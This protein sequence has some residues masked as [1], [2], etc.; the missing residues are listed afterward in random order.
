MSYYTAV[1]EWLELRMNEGPATGDRRRGRVTRD[2]LR[3]TLNKIRRTD[4]ERPTWQPPSWRA[5]HKQTGR[6]T[7]VI[8]RHHAQGIAGLIEPDERLILAHTPGDRLRLRATL[9]FVNDRIEPT[10]SA[11]CYGGRPDAARRQTDRRA[12]LERFRRLVRDEGMRWAAK[13]DIR[14]F[15]DAI[16]HG[17]LTGL[18]HERIGDVGCIRELVGYLGWYWR[19]RWPEWTEPPGEPMGVPQGSPVS[20]ALANIYLTEFDRTLEAAGITFLRYLDDVT[21]LAR[22]PESL[23]MALAE[24]MR[25]L[26]RLAMPLRPEKTQA[27]RLVAGEESLPDLEVPGR[28]LRVPIARDLD[29]LGIHFLDAERFRVREATVDRLL[30]K[31]RA[32]IR[33]GRGRRHELAR[34]FVASRRINQLLGYQVS[35][36]RPGARKKPITGTDGSATRIRVTSRRPENRC[37]I[38]PMRYVQPRQHAVLGHSDLIL[39]QMRRVDRTIRLWMKREFGPVLERREERSSR[40]RGRPPKRLDAWRIRSAARM[41][42][43]AAG[44]RSDVK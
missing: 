20:G 11:S 7:A 19:Q 29:V 23:A 32:E 42:E 1:A 12:A 9:A 44:E 43:I 25:Q 15:F 22:G 14:N 37:W 33:A 41:Y 13:V 24:T 2:L 21:L 40:R 6:M 3:H 30:G 28:G 10:L 34:F 27:A 38:A 8:P 26:D 17:P 39:E 36:R 16:P 31:V 35:R 5:R 18:L 4:P